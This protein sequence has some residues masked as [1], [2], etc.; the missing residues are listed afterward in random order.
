[1]SDR[2][3]VLKFDKKMNVDTLVDYSN[4]LVKINGQLQALSSDV[5]DIS[6]IQ[7]GTAVVITFAET[8]NGKNVVF[9]GGSSTS[10]ANVSELQVLGVKDAAGNL[11]SEFTS[12]NGSNVVNITANKVLELANIS[13]EDAYDGYEAE[14]VDT[15]TVKVKYIK[16]DRRLY[17]LFITIFLT[18]FFLL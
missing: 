4:Y 18:N 15:K 17:I 11:L 12:A 5:A 10:N 8:L 16:S 1:M 14:L 3:V 9:A 2:R 13:T 6:V 7:D